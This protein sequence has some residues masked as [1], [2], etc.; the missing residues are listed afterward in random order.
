MNKIIKTF[1]NENYGFIR[2]T[3]SNKEPMFSFKDICKVLNIKDLNA[4]KTSLNQNGV[5][6]I[7]VLVEEAK[8]KI[9]FVSEANIHKLFVKSSHEDIYGI[10]EWISKYVVPRTKLYGDYTVDILMD[11]PDMIIKV[12]KENEE[13]NLKVK[14]LD[15]KMKGEK[16]RVRTY[17]S[18][19][20]ER[21]SVPLIFLADYFNINGI[22]QTELM[23]ILRG[24]E[25]IQ[26]NDLPY[27][28]HV[29]N[30]HFRI[31]EHR[32]TRNG[33]LEIR[34]TPIVYRAGMNYIRKLLLK[35]AGE[36]NG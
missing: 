18:L 20:G 31:D 33:E 4:A 13:L 35:V 34:Q 19:Y 22:T 5:T 26:A 27:Q 2:T 12:L 36:N 30:G 7:E 23:Q 10:I 14:L 17:D 16:F 28:K 9:T 3:I 8:Q 11:D 1:D 21:E 15:S 32:C 25:V 24:Q 29:D 6:A